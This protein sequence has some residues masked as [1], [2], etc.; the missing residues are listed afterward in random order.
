MVRRH[1]E[2][3]AQSR[4]EERSPACGG[5]PH[6]GPADTAKPEY[7]QALVA[8]LARQRE[9]VAGQR[10]ARTK[11]SAAL[12]RLAHGDGVVADTATAD[13]ADIGQ[14]FEHGDGAAGN[15]GQTARRRPVQVR[16]F[17]HNPLPLNA[18]K[19]PR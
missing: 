7:A 11:P 16:E 6:R 12:P 8:D 9:V 18:Y 1:C 5:N 2:S 19:R 14:A 17:S 4:G 15:L 10:P 3:A 13:G